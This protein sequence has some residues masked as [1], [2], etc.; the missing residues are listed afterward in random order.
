MDY[1]IRDLQDLSHI[2]AK[3]YSA[4]VV[5]LES[6]SKQE[7]E[8]IIIKAVNE[9]RNSR[10]YRSDIVRKHWKRSKA[11]VVWLF[12][13]SLKEYENKSN[14]RLCHCLWVDPDLSKDMHPGPLPKV[15]SE[16]NGI[17]IQWGVL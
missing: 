11:H 1:K 7:I 6:F 15:N 2:G 8:E 3:R 4:T 9:I 12:V 14:L 5:L 13:I 17:K 16:I 10:F